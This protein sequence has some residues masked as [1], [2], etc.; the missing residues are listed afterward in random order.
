[1]NQTAFL[2]AI[3]DCPEDDEPRLAYADWLQDRGDF[4]GEFIRAM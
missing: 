2:Q 3:I 1:M 4:R